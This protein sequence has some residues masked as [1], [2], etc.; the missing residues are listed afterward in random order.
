MAYAYEASFFADT[1]TTPTATV[2]NSAGTALDLQPTGT[3]TAI[4]DGF[5]HYFTDE[6]P[7]GH[8][9]FVKYIRSGSVVAAAT[10]APRE[11]EN[12]DVPTS[13]VTGRS[14]RIVES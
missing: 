1:G 14:V 12:S 9:G 11:T 10:V 8:R 5:F 6:M 2:C 13:N 7:S 3:V 4:G